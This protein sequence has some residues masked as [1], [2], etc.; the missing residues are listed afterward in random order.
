V[1]SL[2]GVGHSH[3]DNVI[4]NH[5]LEELD[6]G[7]NDAWI[8]ERTG[9]RTRRSVLPLDYIRET[10]NA[11]L[12]AASEASSV[13]NVELA[14]R[15]AE[16]AIE[17]A[18][19]DRADI[20]LVIGTGS[21]P[22]HVTPA[23]GCIIAAA[24]GIEAPSFDIRSACTSFG[25]TVHFLSMMNE[26]RLP[27]YVLIVAPETCTR[28][29]DYNDRNSAVLW[30]DAAVA[31]V[32]SA[33][34]KTGRVR[35]ENCSMESKPA[36]FDKVVVPWAGH[37]AQEGATVQSF[38]IKK[39]IRLLRK[40]KEDFLNAAD[41]R[42]HFIG[43]QA[44]ALMLE[45]VTRNCEITADFHHSNVADF[46]NTATAGSPSVLS[47]DWDNFDAGDHVAVIGVGAGLTW[48]SMMLRFEA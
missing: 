18:G 11:D 37:F 32:V 26:E 30:G 20:G 38:A 45:N 44:N 8:T 12:R 5:F 36:G 29:V 41:G 25:A 15:A 10:K 46:G 1:L 24:L 28:V 7:T 48:T 14:R 40:Q 47:S 4:T 39:T 23:E 9:I 34:D 35:I 22:E 17:R 42:L 43:H 6:I 2:H 21:A 31:A 16:M 19:I 13:S 27:P 3:P 33:S